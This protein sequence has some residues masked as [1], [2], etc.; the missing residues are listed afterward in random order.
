MC[1]WAVQATKLAADTPLPFVVVEQREGP[2]RSGELPGQQLLLPS[3][4]PAAGSGAAELGLA[5]QGGASPLVV[6]QP[7]QGELPSTA[8]GK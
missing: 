3:P 7:G 5:G 8:K 6:W 1:C 2:I 4:L